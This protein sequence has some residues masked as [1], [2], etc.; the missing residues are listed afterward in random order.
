[1]ANV[2]SSNRIERQITDGQSRPVPHRFALWRPPKKSNEWRTLS[3]SPNKSSR[4]RGVMKNCSWI[5]IILAIVIW[6]LMSGGSARAQTP[7]VNCSTLNPPFGLMRVYPPITVDPNSSQEGQAFCNT[8]DVALGGGYEVLNPVPPLPTGVLIITPEDSFYY[9]DMTAT[10]WQVLLQNV[11][12]SPLCAF[13]KKGSKHCPS[14]DF[15]VC[16][17]CVTPTP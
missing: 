15:R 12:L 8:G 11:N 6:T 9:S 13:A 16:V 5:V 2:I 14:V 10:G 4:Q 7:Y 1:M 17:S 3:K